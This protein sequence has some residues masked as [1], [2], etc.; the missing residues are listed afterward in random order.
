VAEPSA[1]DLR[2]LKALEGRL[3]KAKSD[4]DELAGERRELRRR[5]QAEERRAREAEKQVEQT[6]S[7][8]GELVEE[9]RALAARLEETDGELERLRGAADELRK[10][11]DENERGAR[12][13]EKGRK[14]LERDLTRV[15]RE[16]DRLAERLKTAE[17]QVKSAGMAPL[18][19]AKEA[20]RLVEQLF[21]EL[22]AGIEGMAVKDGELRLR[23]AFGRAGRSTGFV[24]PTSESPA[25]VRESLQ[26]VVLRFD[27]TVEPPTAG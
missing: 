23:V 18:V 11:L 8:I 24:L 12:E 7:R 1:K 16:R 21:D 15:E 13:A 5:V 6:D 22:G 19:P 14:Q 9:N 3:E 4:R 20:A 17:A 27:R 25:E 26:E 10:R 2:R